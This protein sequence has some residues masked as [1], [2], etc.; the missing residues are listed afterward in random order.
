MEGA[1][2]NANSKLIGLWV[3]EVG[4][5]TRSLSLCRLGM[6]FPY[7]CGSALP[8]GWRLLAVVELLI[9]LCVAPSIRVT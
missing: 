7:Q 5:I 2:P 6:V 4:D 3:A 1:W 9:P 8:Q